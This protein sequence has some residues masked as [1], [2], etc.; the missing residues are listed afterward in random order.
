M[1][2]PT[3]WGLCF[4]SGIMIVFALPGAVPVVGG[5]FGPL[6]TTVPWGVSPKGQGG[7]WAPPPC[8]DNSS[9][10]CLIGVWFSVR[11]FRDTCLVCVCGIF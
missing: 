7:P 2:G 8:C 5:V 9:E 4:V 6:G 1:P 10:T 11:C 3:F